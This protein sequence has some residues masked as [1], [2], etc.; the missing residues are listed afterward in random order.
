MK[1]IS[2][3][4][5]FKVFHW[6]RKSSYL[7]KFSTAYTSAV[8]GMFTNL[9][10]LMTQCVRFLRVY[11]RDLQCSST[12]SIIVAFTRGCPQYYCGRLIISMCVYLKYR[13]LPWKNWS[14]NYH[15]CALF[16]VISVKR[17]TVTKTQEKQGKLNFPPQ[18]T[19]L[20][21]NRYCTVH[22]PEVHQGMT[23]L[24]EG[25]SFS[26]YC[27]N[28]LITRISKHMLTQVLIF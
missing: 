19:I 20:Y 13:V 28:K 21:C 2:W 1:I 26:P 27:L 6:L 4:R 18:N 9:S 17:V 16:F 15:R 11:R 25:K 14:L 24:R 10:T 8:F 7:I 23:N 22:V 3:V 5:V 12:Y